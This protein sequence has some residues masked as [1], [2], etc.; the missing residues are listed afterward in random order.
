[1]H[2]V[3]M[4]SMFS[5]SM[6]C[7]GL[8]YIRI[9]KDRFAYIAIHWGSVETSLDRMTH[10]RWRRWLDW[11]YH[12][13]ISNVGAGSNRHCFAGDFRRIFAISSVVTGWN[14]DSS[15]WLFD[16][17]FSEEMMWTLMFEFAQFLWQSIVKK[18][19][20]VRRLKMWARGY[21]KFCSF[22]HSALELRQQASIADVQWCQSIVWNSARWSA[23]CAR[24]A[25][26]DSLDGFLRYAFS[27]L[28]GLWAS[29]VCIKP[30]CR[31]SSFRSHFLQWHE[32]IQ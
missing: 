8:K 19:S 17:Q 23:N 22:D 16:R 5:F 31:R 26:L 21:I 14:S 32:L 1:M 29:A 27:S 25:N 6:H 2:N 11:W 18:S 30:W 24:Q 10:Y 9:R 20:A 28:F 15:S 12:C 4:G 7:T 13:L 3:S